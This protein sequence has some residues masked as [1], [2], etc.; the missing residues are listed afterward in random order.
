V[1]WERQQ[2]GKV[3]ESAQFPAE[4]SGSLQQLFVEVHDLVGANILTLKLKD[5]M[6]VIRSASES[7]GAASYE[8]V[9][10]QLKQIPI[11]DLKSILL[12]DYP[13]ESLLKSRQTSHF[14]GHSSS[15][16]D[17]SIETAIHLEESLAGDWL[18]EFVF[19]PSPLLSQNNRT[20]ILFQQPQRPLN[21]ILESR[22]YP[23]KIEIQ[24][25]SQKD[26]FKTES[27]IK[28]RYSNRSVS[29]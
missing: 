8:P 21:Q 27:M 25:Q 15:E 23:Q 19:L 6:E 7:L 29:R 13:C 2:N 9:L 24:Q 14:S 22:A 17:K 26:P 10:N 16:P 20:R 28:I 1:K 12:A 3:T 18:K 11:A 4:V 5:Q